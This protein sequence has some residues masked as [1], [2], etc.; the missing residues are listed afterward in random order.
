MANQRG[1]HRAGATGSTLS[2]DVNVRALL[3]GN[4]TAFDA[5]LATLEVR[6]TVCCV[7]AI[8]ALVHA[9][10]GVGQL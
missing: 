1:K 8:L 5:V 10:T 9:P 6:T 2:M 3:K 4:A 7:S